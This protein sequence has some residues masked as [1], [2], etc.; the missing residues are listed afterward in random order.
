MTDMAVPAPETATVPPPGR[1]QE[2]P[3]VDRVG[4][5]FVA[6]F[7]VPFFLFNILPVLFGVYVAFTRWSIVGSP[8]WVGT[9]NFTRAF[10]D[11]WVTVAFQNA[12]LYGVLIVPGVSVLGLAF[13]LFVSRGYPLSGLARTLF[14]APNVV[15]AT[16]IGLVWVW[17]LDTQ[18]GLV[19]HYLGAVGV[20][21]VPWLT[22]TEWSLV[23]VSIASVWWDLGLA[24]VL[25]LAALQDIPADLTEA[26]LVDGA[27]RWQRLFFIVLPQ[28]RPVISM[29]VTLQLIST[30]RIFSQVYVMTNGGPA[31]SSSSPIY[32]IYTMAIVR[33]LFGYASAI[34]LLLFI[35]ILILTLLQ[36]FLL[37][38]RA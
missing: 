31:G 18:F 29:V 1:R 23:G 24:F 6:F 16:V 32:Y 15:S 26:A 8:R 27:G 2:R 3:R 28:L 33:N 20:S 11:P 10:A 19:N 12:L 22:S 25:F 21:A 38:E 37:K 5:L 14:F 35:V 36:R 4:Y 7:A 30:F 9:E 13:A 34:A 17:L